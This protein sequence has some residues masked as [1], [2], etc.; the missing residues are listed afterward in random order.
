MH[1]NDLD[2]AN[3]LAAASKG[4]LAA[5]R[6]LAER[7]GIPESAALRATLSLRAGTAG[8]E[9][10]LSMRAAA[11][12]RS[13]V[14]AAVRQAR[15]A[16][17][18]SRRRQTSVAPAWSAWFDGSAH[19]N[20]GR[21]TIGAVL[22]GPGGVLVELSCGAGYGNSSEAEY[23]ALI[24]VLEAALEHGA[25]PLAIHGDSQVVIDDVNAPD[26]A[27]AAS[28]GA[29]R[30]RA[31]ALLAQLPGATLRWIPRHKNTRADALSQRAALILPSE[32]A[33]E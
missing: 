30:A 18:V 20:P 26:C 14:N 11:R 19:P 32:Q 25:G 24:A 29:Y 17:S 23:L 2:F 5:S 16:A 33:H 13:D 6:K 9:H 31:R 21:C 15:A 12:E 8:L 27:G 10:L 28:L 7:A 1:D 3:L 4:E 22:E